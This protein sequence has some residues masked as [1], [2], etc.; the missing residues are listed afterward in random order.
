[1][2]FELMNIETSEAFLAHTFKEYLLA[3]FEKVAE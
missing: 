3:E 2:N 1:M